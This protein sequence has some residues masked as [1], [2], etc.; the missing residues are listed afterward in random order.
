MQCFTV[1]G[2][3]QVRGSCEEEKR[4]RDQRWNEGWGGGN[5]GGN[6]LQKKKVEA[7]AKSIER[8]G[9]EQKGPFQQLFGKAKKE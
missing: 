1:L 8:G 6:F 9:E 7:P 3:P 4:T 2:G 5:R